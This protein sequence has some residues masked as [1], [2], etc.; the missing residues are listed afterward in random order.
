MPLDTSERESEQEE[1]EAS[2]ESR[3]KTKLRRVVGDLTLKRFFTKKKKN[4][5]MC[6]LL[7]KKNIRNGL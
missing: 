3:G 1:T 4:I 5:K 6:M 7:K 2:N